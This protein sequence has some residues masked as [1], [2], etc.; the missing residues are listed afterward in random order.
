MKFKEYIN[1]LE[2]EDD[3]E[4]M[5]VPLLDF[6]KHIKRGTF[7]TLFDSPDFNKNKK[8]T[9]DANLFKPNG[10][11]FA[12]DTGWINW[13]EDEMPH[14]AQS[15]VF[16]LQLFL[17][18][19]LILNSKPNDEIK[20]YEIED[21]RMHY[22]DW[23]SLAKKYDGIIHYNPKSTGPFSMWDVPGGCV[24]NLKAV[25]NFKLIGLYDKKTKKYE[26]F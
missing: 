25:K 15:A 7:I 5:M 17:P 9:S 4:Y 11:W 13:L 14:W 6:R 8:Y 26:K 16:E 2:I 21:N 22:I 19:L 18:K 23:K 1:E 10:L 3:N 20:K 24:W 12:V